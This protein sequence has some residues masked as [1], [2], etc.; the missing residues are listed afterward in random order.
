MFCVGYVSNIKD[1]CK[2]DSGGGFL[3]FD[4]KRKR[5]KWFFGGIIS[6]GNF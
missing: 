4:L 2:R 1:F 5:K 3:F 6:W